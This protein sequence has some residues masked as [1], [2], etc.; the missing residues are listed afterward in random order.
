[1]NDA[2]AETRH[3]NLRIPFRGPIISTVIVKQNGKQTWK[4]VGSIDE[5]GGIAVARDKARVLIRQIMSGE[6]PPAPPQ[7]VP[8]VMASYLDRHVHKSG[9]KS[10]PELRR[11]NNRL[12]TPYFG[13]LDFV[14]MRRSEL[15]ARLDQIEDK[16]GPGV[17]DVAL[18]TLRGAAGW[19]A[20]RSD[21]YDLRIFA[22]G[23]RRVPTHQ[24]Q[25]SRILSDDELRTVWLATEVA[26][27]LG[28]ILQLELLTAQRR[29]K[30]YKLKWT[31]ID[32]DFVWTVPVEVGQKGVGGRLR[33]PAT[34]RAIIAA[35]PKHASSDLVFPQR[36]STV[37]KGKFEKRI[38]V[39]FRQHDLR[40]TARTMLARL[41]VPFEVAE[42]IM[43]HRLKGVAGIYDRYDREQ[44]KGIALQRLDDAIQQI[45][46]PSPA[47]VVP[48]REAVAP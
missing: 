41:A 26:G 39:F 10:E 31:D 44:E 48:L 19:M 23:M 32:S 3:A 14:R 35:Q 42:A 38:G 15:V 4:V 24:R 13:D 1:V 16:H 12:I 33:L 22:R 11:I 17:A 40:R 8:A 37:T 7:S 18:T 6:P 46:H 30:I 27:V 28:A 36:F 21:D 25:R 20:K 43:G 9:L 29:E 45:V 34:A 47:N 5:L 2:V